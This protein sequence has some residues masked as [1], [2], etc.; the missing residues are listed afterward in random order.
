MDGSTAYRVDN[1]CGENF[2]AFQQWVPRLE[3]K[4]GVSSCVVDNISQ[5]NLFAKNRARSE[6]TITPSALLY[7][8]SLK[9]TGIKQNV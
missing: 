3:K 8:N 5:C 4:K 1:G 6:M 7:M 9:I 2:P